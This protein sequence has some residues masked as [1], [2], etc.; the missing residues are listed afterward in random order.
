MTLTFATLLISVPYIANAKSGAVLDFDQRGTDEYYY[1]LLDA[2]TPLSYHIHD[3][4]TQIDHSPVN[5]SKTMNETVGCALMLALMKGS[6]HV[7]ETNSCSDPR[8]TNFLVNVYGTPAFE[9]VLEAQTAAA[10]AHSEQILRSHPCPGGVWS[11]VD[12]KCLPLPH[13]NFT[14]P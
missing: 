13:L 8:F 11:E 7:A 12:Q 10:R 5:D 4:I 2:C 1:S 9:Q 3:N 6:C 14:L